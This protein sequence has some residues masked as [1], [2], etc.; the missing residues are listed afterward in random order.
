MSWLL[1]LGSSGREEKA[2]YRLRWMSRAPSTFRVFL[3]MQVV[4]HQEQ[5]TSGIMGNHRKPWLLAGVS[6][7]S[8]LDLI[9][10]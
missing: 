9:I 8:A 5:V 3:F 2:W 7:N 10:S 1:F 4:K 6:G